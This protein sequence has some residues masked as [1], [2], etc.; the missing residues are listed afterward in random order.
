MVI[1]ATLLTDGALTTNLT[2]YDT[3]SISPTAGRVLLVFTQVAGIGTP[4]PTVVSGLSGQWSNVGGSFRYNSS[5]D[6]AVH[7]CTNYSGSGILNIG[8]PDTGAHV[9]WAVIEID[10]ANTTAPVVAGTFSTASPGSA[11]GV[12]VNLPAATNANNRVFAA[13]GCDNSTAGQAAPRA[14]WTELSDRGISTPTGVLET[15]WRSDAHEATASVTWTGGPYT[16]AGIAVEIAAAGTASNS[17]IVPR[18]PIGAL[19]DM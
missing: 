11:N 13:F 10:G 1:S 12:T 8:N 14:S 7:W 2:L 18:R 6:L 19:L 15:Q 16:S 4:T 9:I 3:A 17:L 5:L